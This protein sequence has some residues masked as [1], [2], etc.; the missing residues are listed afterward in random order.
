MIE[1]ERPWMLAGV[2]LGVGLWWWAL[3][4]PAGVCLALPQGVPPVQPLA[5]HLREGSR[6]LALCALAFAAAGP[7]AAGPTAVRSTEGVAIVVALDISE[8]MRTEPLGP[9]ARLDVALQELERFLAGRAG[10]LVGLVTFAGEASTRVPPTLDRA[11]LRTALAAVPREEPGDGTA[12]GSALG[13]AANRLRSLDAPSKVIL[14]ITDGESNAGSLDPWTAA[15]AAA[16]VGARVYAMGV[17]SAGEATLRGVA[18]AGGGRYFGVDDREGLDRAYRDID[19]L[20]PSSFLEPVG[21]PA[22]EPR[23][24]GFLWLALAVLTLEGALRASPRG[25]TP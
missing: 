12:L 7:H 2:V 25:G 4:R 22:E 8:S 13:L 6:L 16:A 21:P 20:E 19:A 17:G 3:R 18:E 5:P 24:A 10:D 15:G 23:H 1:L 9:D 11:P 14:A